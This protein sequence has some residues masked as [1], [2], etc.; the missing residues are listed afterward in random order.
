MKIMIRKNICLLT[1]AALLAGGIQ[2]PVLAQSADI[3]GNTLL[4]EEGGV[5]VNTTDEFMAAL[6]QHK[7]PITVN[8][9][10][11]IG[12]EAD[13]DGGMLPVKIPANT[14]IR[15]T[16]N[17]ILNSRSPVQLEGD[18]C[19]QDIE[20]TFES[21]DAL[22]SVPHREIFLAGHGLTF[23]NV[24][25]WLEGGDG[26]F[27]SLGGTEK[28]LLPTVY[29]GGYSNTDIGDNAFLTVRNSNAETMFQAVYM[30]HDAESDN[31]VPYRGNATVSL[32]AGVT[33]RGRVDVSKNSRAE[34]QIAGGENDHAKA[35]E[36][37]GNENTTLTLTRSSITEAVVEDVGNIV[38]TDKACLESKTEN[39]YNV[40]L[41]RGGCLDLSQLNDVLISGDFTGT[42]DLEE[43]GILVVNQQGTLT[44]G[45]KVTGTTTFQTYHR[46]FPGIFY[47]D[48]PYISARQENVSGEPFVLSEK[49][50]NDGYE[51]KYTNGVWSAQRENQGEEIQIGSIEIV[52]APSQVVLQNISTN[53][54]GTVPDETVYFEIV[55]RDKEGQVISS[56]EVE[57]LALYEADYIFKIKTEYWENDDPDIL[58]KT[59]W[60][61][62]VTFV[63]SQEH[64]GRYY[65]QAEEGAK[66]GDYTFLFCSDYCTDTL[67]TVQDVKQLKNIV[68]AEQRVAFLDKEPE[69]SPSPS[70]AV[71]ATPSSSPAVSAPP[72]ESQKPSLPPIVSA[73]PSP[74]V[75]ATPSSSPVVSASPE[76]VLP[77]A[78]GGAP[79]LP[80]F[81]TYQ[82]ILTRATLENDGMLTRICS[83]GAIESRQTI[84]RPERILLSADRFIY[85]G[86]EQR[87]QVTV[88][89]VKETVIDSK[90]YE[91]VYRN[92]KKV[93][94]ASVTIRF[95]GNYSGEMVKTF[96]I[97]PKKTKL[98]GVTA[99]SGG[100]L[101]KWK[102]QNI[103]STGYEIQYSVS[104]KFTG[105]NLKK[106]LVKN[107]KKTS[108]FV[109][110][111]SRAKK[112]YVR[113]RTYKNVK[114][115]GRTKRF[116]SAWSE[117]RSVTVKK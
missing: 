71:S 84:Y 5:T 61:N 19:F 74:V 59:D 105:K 3:S 86:K 31:K 117:V 112:Y 49:S 46:L 108:R 17:G 41:Q 38:L 51:L 47:A 80:H 94:Q 67:D 54:E 109:S 88:M 48:W 57:E 82:T 10:I 56:E 66:A 85:T 113:I 53:E 64:P 79:E 91:V 25:T 14:L 39:L 76:P 99:R 95:A 73:S 45:G 43:R 40:T 11:T 15:G 97:V 70:P 116:C 93:G 62:S 7:S 13:T 6:D 36:Y 37:Y 68:K 23:D 34:I 28:E 21:T 35:K 60:N 44:I 115:N 30:G 100:F 55:W 83:C 101:V 106:V 96:D 29:A 63:T 110:G 90:N 98:A 50:I 104:K 65:L 26:E 12:K 92:N 8:T 107:R 87:P 102:K 24:S 58:E 111:K 75:S 4:A 81:H 89:D 1:V 27:G 18:V 22:G 32:D 16:E 77:P 20:L 2:K 69:Q 9:M 114:V 103:Q 42:G 33:V 72:E 78:V 52:S